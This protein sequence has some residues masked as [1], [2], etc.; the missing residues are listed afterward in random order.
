LHKIPAGIRL[1]ED[2]IA[3]HPAIKE[4]KPRNNPKKGIPGQINILNGFNQL[5]IEVTAV[6][7]DHNGAQQIGVRVEVCWLLYKEDVDQGE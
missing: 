7:D 3:E 5:I 6:I 4:Q 1:K 2:V